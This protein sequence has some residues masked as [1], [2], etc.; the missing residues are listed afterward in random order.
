MPALHKGGRRVNTV[1][2]TGAASYLPPLD[3]SE[4]P[5]NSNL[6]DLVLLT[7]RVGSSSGAQSS[8]PL[9]ISAG[10]PQYLSPPCRSA[11]RAQA[12]ARADG[13]SRDMYSGTP[14]S[15][16]HRWL[17]DTNHHIGH[18]TEGSRVALCSNRWFILHRDILRGVLLTGLAVC[19]VSSVAV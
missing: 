12:T 17:T 3:Q 15:V 9:G 7:T 1:R 5:S 13:S 4:R 18:D 8:E 2:W 6:D 11:G 10:E 19:P 16:E 14:A